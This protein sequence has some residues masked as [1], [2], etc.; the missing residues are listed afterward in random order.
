PDDH[1]DALEWQLRERIDDVQHHRTPAQRVQDLG[2]ARTHPCALTRREH[3]GGERPVLAHGCIARIMG[4]PSPPLARGR[5]FEPRLRTPKDLVLPLHHP[6]T[7]STLAAAAGP[8][9]LF[10]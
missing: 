4:A 9:C 7:A 10:W 5:G 3:D 8:I 6:R 2:G 1:D